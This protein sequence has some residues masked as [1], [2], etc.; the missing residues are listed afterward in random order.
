[1]RCGATLLLALSLAGCSSDKTHPPEYHP[2][3]D[4]ATVDDPKSCGEIQAGEPSDKDVLVDGQVASCASVSIA[5]PLGNSA[6]FVAA[7]DG[8]VPV[9][10]CGF[11]L[12]W[13]LACEIDTGLGDG[14]AD[15]A[16][17]ADATSDAAID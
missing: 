12:T 8:G 3:A 16:G 11:A 5:C 17:D 1:M 9:A 14:G 6:S 15:A 10:K 4:A 13:V 7:C 2:P